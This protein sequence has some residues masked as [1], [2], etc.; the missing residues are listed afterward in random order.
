ML[1]H[2]RSWEIEEKVICVL[3]DN[4]SNL[5]AG[6]NNANVK[7]L[8]CLA[9]SLQLIIKDGIL[10]Q[11]AVQQLLNP[12]RS[13]VGH[14]HHSNVAFQIFCQIQSQLKLPEHVLIQDVSEQFLLHASKTC[15]TKE[16]HS[17]QYRMSST[18]Q[19]H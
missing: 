3:C 4:A 18:W 11:P 8:S 12:A 10:M 16:S 6:M 14:Y 7:S 13:L 19:T 17:S 15:R 5:I 1:T 9:H 2:I